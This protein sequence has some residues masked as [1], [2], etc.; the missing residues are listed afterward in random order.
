M[1]YPKE[2]EHKMYM[3]YV[4]EQ[5]SNG[6]TPLKKDEWRKKMMGKQNQAMNDYQRTMPPVSD[7]SSILGNAQ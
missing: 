3:D 6:A 4:I 7:N 2:D 1:A 5:Q